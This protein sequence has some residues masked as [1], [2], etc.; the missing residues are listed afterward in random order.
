MPEP[1]LQS[2][3]G[4]AAN[5]SNSADRTWNNGFLAIG[6]VLK[7][8]HKRYTADVIMLGSSNVI[9]SSN[10]NEG[11]HSCRIG[12][13]NAGFDKTFQKPYG[14]IVP[15]QEGSLVLVGFMKNKR[16]KPVILRVFHD[17]GEAVGENNTK[18]ILDVNFL[19]TTKLSELD[20]RRYTNVLRTQDFV[21][22]DGLGNFE[23]SS[24][25]K[26]F[27]AGKYTEEIDPENYG[28]EELSV[29]DLNQQTVNLPPEES[30]PM[31]FVAAV[32]DS[33][34]S[35][36]CNWLRFIVD[37]AKTVFKLA[38]QQRSENKLS[39]LEVSETGE[40][41]V[42]RQQDSA[43][44][45]SGVDYTELIIKTDGKIQVERTKGAKKTVVTVDPNEVNLKKTGTKTTTMKITDSEVS[46]N[47]D[48][49]IK[50]ESKESIE[51]KVKSSSLKLSS[52]GVDVK[53][54]KINLNE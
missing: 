26:A 32:Q 50:Y 46:I 21:T 5:N 29:K 52:G 37:A 35:G 20:T 53:G 49:P 12:V 18:N 17:I 13:G 14:E 11:K 1:V 40:I 28:Y 24:H 15:I 38:K 3:L 45:D 34:D 33:Y 44:F 36:S 22:I 6:R 42:R 47:T 54:T 8:H 2:S 27:F 7:V 23:V 39:L 4:V 30:K 19:N 10:E 43:V 51:L 48:N 41:K 9:M 16:E 25:T 31:K